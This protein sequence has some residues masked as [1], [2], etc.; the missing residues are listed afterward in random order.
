MKKII[1]TFLFLP[2]VI[3]A[4]NN[5]NRTTDINNYIQQFGNSIENGKSYNNLTMN[6]LLSLALDGYV[7]SAE[8]PSANKWSAVLDS[9]E[10]S[11]SLGYN[12]DYRD[13][14]RAKKLWFLSYVGFTNKNEPQGSFFTIFDETNSAVSNLGLDLRLSFFVFDGLTPKSNTKSNLD[15][16][17]KVKLNKLMEKEFEDSEEI[18]TSKALSFI[19]LEEAKHIIKTNDFLEYTRLWFN[20]NAFIPLT[21]LNYDVTAQN[22]YDPV[23]VGFKNW[24]YGLTFNG[25]KKWK[26]MSGTATIG[27]QIFNNNNIQIKELKEKEYV[28]L[29][30]VGNG[31]QQVESKKAYE[32]VF[33]RFTTRQIRGEITT[34]LYKEMIGVSAAFQKNY[35]INSNLNWKLGIPLS[36][37]DAKGESS[38]NFELQWREFN[39]DHF[40]GISVGKSFGKFVN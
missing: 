2:W 39:G 16:F 15:N 18:K 35:G 26:K 31:F 34:L 36:L 22:T 27:Y 11:L 20:F 38:V 4:Q 5:G 8:V 32:G 12:F 37:K 6:S 9:D 21:G 23:K 30:S 10:N 25:L 19:A 17:R 7:I 14:D 13:G 29:T 1:I 24:N 28:S 3:N 33:E 40:I